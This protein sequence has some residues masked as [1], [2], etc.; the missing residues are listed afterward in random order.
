MDVVR[1]R[2]LLTLWDG[3]PMHESDLTIDNTS[4]S[5]KEVA[6]QIVSHFDLP[7]VVVID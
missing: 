2:E 7:R 1:L 3:R 6:G 4:I 5:A